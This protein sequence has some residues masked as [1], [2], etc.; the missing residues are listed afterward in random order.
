ME[1]EYGLALQLHVHFDMG[2]LRCG[3]VCSSP[4]G[5]CDDFGRLDS[6]LNKFCCDAANFLHR[7][8]DQ[9]P[10]PLRVYRF[11]FGGGTALA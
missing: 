8:V 1:I 6:A 7:P 10:G 11:V 5:P 9:R 4:D 3:L 2:F